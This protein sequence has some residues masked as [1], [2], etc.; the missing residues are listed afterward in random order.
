VQKTRKKCTVG[1]FEKNHVLPPGTIH[2]KNG[3]DTRA[4][5]K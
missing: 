5:K 1:S 4:D 2:N 3:R